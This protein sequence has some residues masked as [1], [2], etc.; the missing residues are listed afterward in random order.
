MSATQMVWCNS[1]SVKYRVQKCAEGFQVERL[2][3]RRVPQDDPRSDYVWY[4]YEFLVDKTY[5]LHEPGL[6]CDPTRCAQAYFQGTCEHVQIVRQLQRDWQNLREEY[7][8]SIRRLFAKLAERLRAL[9]QELRQWVSHLAQLD[10][11]RLVQGVYVLFTPHFL[12]QF[13]TRQLLLIMRSI[14]F[15]LEAFE[16]LDRDELILQVCRFNKAQHGG[17]AFQV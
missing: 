13:S 6:T 10:N 11:C 3:K 7:L 15:P 4:K 14:R 1:S 9:M 16:S 8:L 12:S 5:V 2:R 17:Y